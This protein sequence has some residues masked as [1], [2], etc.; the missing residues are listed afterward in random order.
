MISV[1]LPIVPMAKG[2]SWSLFNDEV[3]CVYFDYEQMA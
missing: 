3:H 2:L 1:I